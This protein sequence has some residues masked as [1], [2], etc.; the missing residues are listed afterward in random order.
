[1]QE[2]QHLRKRLADV[3]QAPTRIMLCIQEDG[4]F[5]VSVEWPGKTTD[6]SRA[7]TSQEAVRIAADDLLTP[8]Y[9]RPYRG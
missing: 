2:L 8:F 5:F 1:M 3:G 9:N 4:M 6:C 7:T